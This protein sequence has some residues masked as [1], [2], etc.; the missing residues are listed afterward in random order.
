MT[1]LLAEADKPFQPLKGNETIISEWQAGRMTS[2]TEM[3]NRTP[4]YDEGK[5]LFVFLFF[6][7][8]KDFLFR[9]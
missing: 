6:V 5:F 2:L 3:K 9:K 8:A 1:V 4:A 7:Y